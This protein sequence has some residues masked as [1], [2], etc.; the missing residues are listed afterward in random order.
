[1]IIMSLYLDNIYGFKDFSI[2]FT[3]P[4][5]KVGSTI[6]GEFLSDRPR[7]RYK[8][9]NIIMG[10]NATGKTTLG[11]AMMGIFNFIAKKDVKH[12]TNEI[13][14][15]TIDAKFVIEFVASTKTL[16]RVETV[17]IADKELRYR[18]SN[19]KTKLNKVPIKTND[20]YEKCK[21]LLDTIAIN[22]ESYVKSFDEIEP[23]GWYFTFPDDGAVVMNLDED[24]SDLFAKTLNIVMKLLDPAIEE[25]TKSTE[26]ENAFIIKH[27][28]FE[29]VIQNG[30]IMGSENFFSSGTING[31]GIALLLTAIMTHRHGFYYCDE[32]YSFIQSI[33]EKELLA[34]MISKLGKDEQF[35]FTT[36]NSDILDMNLPHH[37]FLFLKKSENKISALFADEYLKRNTDNLRNAVENDIFS[38][39]PN[40]EALQ[41]FDN[42][43]VY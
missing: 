33:I 28:S 9:V 3:Y 6:E 8:K 35:F 7:F 34:T 12:I 42:I 26:L 23:F 39:A 36:H 29:S 32:K 13:C 27:K 31:I 43:E 41:E 30:K 22:N 14:D 11:K 24:N 18:E 38:I 15:K 1:M 25:I 2:N 37:S 20:T 4:K 16:Y 19:I 21:E 17:I 10:S 5:K 40:S